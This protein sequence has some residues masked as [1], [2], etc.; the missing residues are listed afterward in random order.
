MLI[1][2]AAIADTHASTRRSIPS[3]SYNGNMTGIVIRNVIA[4]DPSNMT[5][6]ARSAV[7]VTIRGG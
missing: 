3:R 5:M 1:N 7:P 2:P 6:A 4:P